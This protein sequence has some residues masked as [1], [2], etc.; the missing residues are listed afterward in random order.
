MLEI[1]LK[2]SKLPVD[3]KVYNDKVRYFHYIAKAAF[4]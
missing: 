4:I 1:D 2:M 3:N